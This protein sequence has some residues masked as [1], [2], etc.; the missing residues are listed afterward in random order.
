MHADY[1]SQRLVMQVLEYSSKLLAGL[2]LLTKP[3][4]QPPSSRAFF[5]VVFYGT[6][7]VTETDCPVWEDYGRERTVNKEGFDFE[8]FNLVSPPPKS[9]PTPLRHG[10]LLPETRCVSIWR[11]M[12]LP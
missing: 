3:I 8:R 1:S 4:H 12:A 10:L 9:L 6:E 5:K 2:S 11:C 7:T